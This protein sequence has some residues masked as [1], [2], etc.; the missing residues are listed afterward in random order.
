MGS[1]GHLQLGGE[2]ITL[3]IFRLLKV[4][5]SD[6]LLTAVTTGDIESDK[7]EDLINSELNDRFLEDGKFKTGSLLKC[8][9]KENP[10][11]DVAFK[12]AL[13]DCRKSLTNSLATST[14]TTT[15]LLH[16]VG[17]CRSRQT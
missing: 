3:R 16:I 1:S 14:P 9:D 10:E 7:L 11:G 6:F 17:S 2:L 12:D 15:N 8:I 4:A 5:I 13:D